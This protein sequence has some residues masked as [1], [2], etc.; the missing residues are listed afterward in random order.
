M[1][2]VEQVVQDAGTVCVAAGAVAPEGEMLR[3]GRLELVQVD[4]HVDPAFIGIGDEFIDERPVRIGA[5]P[6][7]GRKGGGLREADRQRG[8]GLE[9]EPE[10]G[11]DRQPDQPRLPVFDGGAEGC[12]DMLTARQP[13]ERG[14]VDAAEHD[15]FAAPVDDVAAGDRKLIFGSERGK[16]LCLQRELQTE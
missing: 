6:L 16:R 9:A 8:F 12:A 2:L 3:R 11:A 1:G 4:K 13:F 15:G 10:R 7:R 14:D 5:L